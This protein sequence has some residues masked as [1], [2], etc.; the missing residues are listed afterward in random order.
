MTANRPIRRLFPILLLNLTG[1]AIAI[2]VLPALAYAVGG[3]AL[4]VGL[5]YAVQSLGQFLM[6]PIWGKFSDRIGRKPILLGTF[7]AAACMELITA[8]IGSLGLLYVARFLVGLCAG[9]VATASAL[10]ADST[11]GADRSKGMAIIGIS[12][13]IGFTLGPAIGAGIG[14]L[15]QPGV[16]G[17][18]GAGLPFAVAAGMNVLT[19]VLGYFLL[20]EPTRSEEIRSKNRRRIP[21]RTIWRQLKNKP[22]FLLCSLFF[23]YTVSLTVLEGT[24]FIYMEAIYGYDIV[25]VGLIFAAMGLVMVLFH[26]AVGPMS[27]L[28]GD[29]RMTFTG[30]LL[31][32]I[33]LTIAPIYP[34]LW[35]LFTFLGIATFGRALVHPGVLAMMSAQSTAAGETGQ[36]MGILQ[37]A[38]SL[39]RIIGP[40]VGG[41]LFAFVSPSTPFYFAGGLLLVTAAIWWLLWD[42]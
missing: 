38:A 11:E 9:N 20:I 32:G 19:V 31:L 25:E 39:G 17:I 12:F 10:I 29:R 15:A 4:D 7:A 28:L 36:L 13:G 33:G 6:A 37:S 23:L 8:F 1:F 5:L 34:P 41:M 3:S 2:P 24:F 18:T 35:F 30:I 26:G 21:T 42:R 14:F 16:A 22:I 40:A 27:R